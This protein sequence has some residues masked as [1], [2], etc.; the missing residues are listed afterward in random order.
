MSHQHLVSVVI[1]FLNAE[2]FIEEAIESIFAQTYTNWELL[3][4][5]DGSNDGSEAVAKRYAEQHQ[6]KVRYLT[7]PNRA[8]RGMSASRNLGFHHAQGRY[9]A[10]LD[11]DDV[12]LSNTLED[13]TSILASEP[14]AAM[15][16]GPL[17]WWYSWSGNPADATRDYIQ[18]LDLPLGRLIKPPELL[19][20]FLRRDTAAPSGMLIRR[21]IIEV[22]GGFEEL[23]RGMYE[24][25]AFCAKVCLVAPVFV[26]NHRWYKYR[27]HPQSSGAQAN[28]SGMYEFGRLAFLEWLAVYLRQQQNADL[29]LWRVLQQEIWL[30][31]HPVIHRWLKQLKRR[32]RHFKRRSNQAL[33]PKRL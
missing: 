12:W 6:G 24:D 15:V 27:Q 31:R 5:D 1:I 17:E 16:Y 11:A 4:I 32:V 25:Q 8:N 21:E 10:Y 7:H 29:Q 9:V 33:L 3:L 13:Q 23:F 19:I 14:T 22:V 28:A 30:V 20:R 2:P 18:Q 26:A